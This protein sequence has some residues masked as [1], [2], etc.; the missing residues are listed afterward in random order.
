MATWCA[1]FLGFE[2]IIVMGCDAYQD[3]RRYWHSL[4]RHGVMGQD[5]TPWLTV[6]DQMDRP[7][8]VRFT[9]K[10]LNRLWHAKSN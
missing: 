2:E 3:D 1:G 8:R 10:E 7:E 4:E 6:R 5:C 9:D